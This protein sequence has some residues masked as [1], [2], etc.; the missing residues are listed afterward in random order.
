MTEKRRRLRF[1]KYVSYASIAVIIY[2]LTHG[3]TSQGAWIGAIGACVFFG[4]WI[5]VGI[6]KYSG[7]AAQATRQAVQPLPT[8]QRIVEQF[9][10]PYGRNPSLVELNSIDAMLRRRRNEDV[11][12]AGA[13][14][15]APFLA[16]HFF[17]SGGRLF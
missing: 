12:K 2:G 1:S 5:S 8:Y 9:R 3:S 4:F 10:A 15:G 14:I 16:S 11:D 13:L 7:L 17:K 6:W